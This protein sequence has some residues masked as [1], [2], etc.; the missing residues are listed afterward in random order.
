[1]VCDLE[2][3]IC[4][5]LK[6]TDHSRRFPKGQTPVTDD[7]G[8]RGHCHPGAKVRGGGQARA[9]SPLLDMETQAD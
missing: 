7:E 2:V 4:G 8:I 6:A 3:D 5:D 9:V 1:M